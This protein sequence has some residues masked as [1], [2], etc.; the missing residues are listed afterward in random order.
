MYI[1]NEYAIV[2]KAEDMTV[3]TSTKLDADPLL[4]VLDCRQRFLQIVCKFLP[5]QVLKMD[6]GTG[7]LSGKVSGV[8]ENY[9]VQDYGK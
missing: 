9:R 4:E 7:T 8:G 3:V 6:A 1:G 5:R 2:A